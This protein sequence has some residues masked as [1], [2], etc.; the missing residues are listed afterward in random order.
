MDWL[1][2]LPPG[3]LALTLLSLVAVNRFRSDFKSNWLLSAAGAAISLLLF[4]YLRIPLP[5]NFLV[6]QSW[7]LGL[8]DT[9][10]ALSWS[11][12]SISMPLAMAVAA[13]LFASI[14][15]QVQRGVTEEWWYWAPGIALALAAM[16]AVLAG[17]VV[18]LAIGWTFFDGLLLAVSLL[19][20]R[21][22]DDRPL[23][24]ANLVLGLLS[25]LLLLSARWL[26]LPSAALSFTAIPPSSL[27]LLLL[28]AGLRLGILPVNPFPLPREE[29]R[30][31]QSLLLRVLPAV[32]VLPL[33]AYIA[34]L[35]LASQILFLI[36]GLVAALLFA[37]RW[38]RAA[39]VR[40]GFTDWVL[41]MSALVFCTTALGAPAATQALALAAILAGGGLFLQR[42][43]Y[44]LR[45]LSLAG[46][47]V[48]LLGL[49]FSPLHGLAELLRPGISPLAYLLFL[50]Y[51]LLVFGWLRFAAAAPEMLDQAWARAV[52]ALGALSLPVLLLLFGLGLAPDLSPRNLAALP[53]WGAAL[54]AAVAGLAWL[55][56]RRGALLPQTISEALLN[57]FSMGWLFRG[58]AVAMAGLEWLMRFA[59]RLL[60]G[61]AGLLWAL[62]FVT[63][64]LSVVTQLAVGS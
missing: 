47:L 27:P 4:L 51:G 33:L 16:L 44:R 11:L 10:L 46:G 26:V 52:Y 39:S 63:L 40:A 2:F 32:I 60:E 8:G 41:G 17:N 43:P 37:A 59:G 13:L 55:L 18:T 35:G 20:L 56:S 21:R 19:W 9:F 23:I 38:V 25:T 24:M 53:A 62:V 61:R 58:L 36:L 64:L 1:L 22:S 15:V 12:S 42:A 34:A 7:A 28:A 31:E 30:A 45:L 5:L 29:A 54:V 49:P 50:P 3:V 48:L 14:V 6:D 57:V